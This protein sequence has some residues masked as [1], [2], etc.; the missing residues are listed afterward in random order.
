M[1][2][3]QKDYRNQEKYHVEHN[4]VKI[5]FGFKIFREL[6]YKGTH[7]NPRG[8]LGLGSFYNFRIYQLTGKCKFETIWIQ[9]ACLTCT[10][11]TEMKWS[12]CTTYKE[13]TRYSCIYN[14]LSAKILDPF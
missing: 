13:Q 2:W 3:S 14:C 7:K 11:Q 1:K 12:P 8:E 6:E 4:N 5:T 10:N 9:C